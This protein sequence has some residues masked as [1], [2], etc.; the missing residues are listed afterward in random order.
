MQKTELPFS[1]SN[2]GISVSDLSRFAEGWLLD[3]EIRQH[4]QATLDNRRLVLNNLVWFLNEKNYDTCSTLELRQFFAYVTRGDKGT[5]GRWGHADLDNTVRPST[6]R[7]YHS[8]LRTFF[9]WAVGEGAIAKSP[10]DPIA[11]PIS[12]TDQI[13]PFTEPQVGALL[14]ASK[15][16]KHP[17]RDEAI[18]MF[19]L[20]TG[21]RAS[22]LCG[23]RFG[24]L[25]L[26]GRRCTVVGKGNK[27]RAIFFGQTT[28]KAL[29]NYLRGGNHES[30]SP[31]FASDRGTS[32]GD[33]F[34]RSGLFQLIERLGKVA[35]V[36][37][38]RCSPHTFRHTFAISFL[39][40]GGNVFTLQQILG[41]TCLQMTNRYV[42]LAQADIERQHRQYSPVDRIRRA[43]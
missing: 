32:A 35:K 22:E 9:R 24:D 23:L 43:K 4:S 7:T 37:A 19:L 6:V 3:C 2:P 12:R 25:D 5:P 14:A 39:R 34:T 13:Q 20:D 29:W 33:A 40:N 26:P 31:L 27:V 18:V 30:A 28:A 1:N 17:R 21:V 15:K 42:A 11:P 16:S 38:T 41:H 10:L 36:E 8:R